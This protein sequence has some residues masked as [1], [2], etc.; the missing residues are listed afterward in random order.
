M[1][2][3]LT[4]SFSNTSTNLEKETKHTTVYSHLNPSKDNLSL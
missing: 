2:Q 1:L 3:L 4:I